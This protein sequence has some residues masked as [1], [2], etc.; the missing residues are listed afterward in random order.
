MCD[1]LT[2]DKFKRQHPCISGRYDH[3]FGPCP[4]KPVVG[5]EDD[6]ATR[7]CVTCLLRIYMDDSVP[8]GNCLYAE[9]LNAI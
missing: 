7:D 8:D 3:N 4:D 2:C 9:K 5:H 1:A 6:L